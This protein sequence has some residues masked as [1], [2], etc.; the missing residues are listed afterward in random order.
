MEKSSCKYGDGVIDLRDEL[1]DI[2]LHVRSSLNV[3]MKNHNVP[4]MY[5]LLIKFSHGIIKNEEQAQKF[6]VVL[7]LLTN[8][9]TF[10][11]I[12][13]NFGG[14]EDIPAEVVP[15]VNASVYPSK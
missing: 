3:P 4:K 5:G 14:Q 9:I 11:L 12:Y 1:K 7:I 8:I 15:A 6:F 10:Y 13:K 2:D